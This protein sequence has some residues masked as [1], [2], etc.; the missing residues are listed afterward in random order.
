MIGAAGILFRAPSG[1]VLL[2]LRSKQVDDASGL[3]ALPGGKIEAGEDAEG[4]A[5][6]EC[7]EEIGY[8]APTNNL[9]MRRVKDGVDFSTFLFE[10]EDE[11]VPKLN[12]EHTAYAWIDPKGLDLPI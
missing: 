3:W 5:F 11:F 2:V 1:R 7:V 6:R 12:Y 10:C 8:R 9:L 4:A